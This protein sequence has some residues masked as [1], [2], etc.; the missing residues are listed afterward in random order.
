MK[1]IL[2]VLILVLL[3][4]GCGKSN[5]TSISYDELQNKIDNKDT[6]VLYVGSSS[7][8][9]CSAYKPVLEKVLKKYN[10]NIFYIDVGV[11]SEAKYNAVMR[12]VDG[13]GTPTTVYIEK[14]KTKTSPKIVGFNEYGGDEVIVKF[15]KKIG[16]IGD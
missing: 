12:K 2:T 3:L 6:F 7:C 5:I 13:D 4:T 8:S 15:F 10:I 1:K 16:Y 9:H 11:L 14:G